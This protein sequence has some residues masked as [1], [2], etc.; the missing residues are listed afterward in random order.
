MNCVHCN[1]PI[2]SG[3]VLCPHY[4]GQAI[5]MKHCKECRH[6][7]EALSAEIRCRYYDREVRMK[8]ARKMAAH[9]ADADK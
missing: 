6:G 4:N 3:A 2:S 9:A 1:M 7:Y 5:C 8:L